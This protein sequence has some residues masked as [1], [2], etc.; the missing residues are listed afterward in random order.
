MS[1]PPARLSFVEEE[2]YLAEPLEKLTAEC[3]VR[4]T[5]SVN[6]HTLL[7]AHTA[8]SSQISWRTFIHTHFSGEGV[9]CFSTRA[10]QVLFRLLSCNLCPGLYQDGM[11]AESH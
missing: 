10:A 8:M 1:R 5:P 11:Q 4:G 9:T 3:W 7:K 6:H 2:P